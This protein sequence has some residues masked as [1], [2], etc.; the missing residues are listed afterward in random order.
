LWNR[1]TVEALNCG[2]NAGAGTGEG[3][4][5]ERQKSKVIGRQ[6]LN[7][8]HN[9]LICQYANPDKLVTSCANC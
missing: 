3:K 9:V 6:T 2:R 7:T 4:G 8:K 1:G 5:V